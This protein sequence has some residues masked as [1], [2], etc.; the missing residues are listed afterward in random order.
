MTTTERIGI[1]TRNY[2]IGSTSGRTKLSEISRPSV[3]SYNY[4]SP[5]HS[6]EYSH[7]TTDRSDVSTTGKCIAEEPET[8]TTLKS[9]E[10]ELTTKTL[11]K[12]PLI[13]ISAIVGDLPSDNST[14]EVEEKTN[15]DHAPVIKEEIEI[16]ERRQKP[17][18][19]EGD[20]MAAVIAEESL[21]ISALVKTETVESLEE[22]QVVPVWE[23]D[24]RQDDQLAPVTQ[25]A[26]QQKRDNN[27]NEV[28]PWEDE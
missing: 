19:D 2:S 12:A 15:G 3:L 7:M 13:S 17:E 1:T 9:L 22:A 27:V 26:P 6:F 28:C 21:A 10:E 14:V 20:A 18:A 4:P 16:E 8:S 5:Q 11:T 24:P 23:P 25:P